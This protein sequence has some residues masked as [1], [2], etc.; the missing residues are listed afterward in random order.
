MTLK[1]ISE[2]HGMPSYS[3]I[4]KWRKVYPWADELIENAIQASLQAL[5]DKT[6]EMIKAPLDVLDPKE[7]QLEL[8]H[9]RLKADFAKFKIKNLCKDFKNERKTQNVNV[10][11]DAT[12]QILNYAENKKQIGDGL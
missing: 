8:A 5:V 11:G 12:V 9:R 4:N 10:S 2:V 1:E 3:Q 6:E 7:A